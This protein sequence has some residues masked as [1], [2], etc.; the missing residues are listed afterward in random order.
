MGTSWTVVSGAIVALL[1]CLP[2][3]W[4]YELALKGGRR[5]GVVSVELG[6]ACILTSFVLMSVAVLVVHCTAEEATL[7]F[8]CAM[9]VTF[10]VFWG[11]ES[12]RGWRAANAAGKAG[13]KDEA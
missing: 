4:L 6:L 1:A 5:S 2:A 7:P 9:V 11:A 3:A 8:G 12:V 10:L 13:G